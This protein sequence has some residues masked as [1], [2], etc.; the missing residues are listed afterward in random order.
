[1]ENAREL[2]GSPKRSDQSHSRQCDPG[3]ESESKAAKLDTGG[4]TGPIVRGHLVT[5]RQ[6]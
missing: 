6:Y 2:R 4:R 5:D 1:M 3:S